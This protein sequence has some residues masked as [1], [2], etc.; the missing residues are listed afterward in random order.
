MSADRLKFFFETYRHIGHIVFGNN[1]YNSLKNKQLYIN[2][3]VLCAYVFKKKMTCLL[4]TRYCVMNKNKL[5]I[6]LFQVV[7]NLLQSIES[8]MFTIRQ[9]AI[10]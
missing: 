5:F 9:S 7:F 10:A 4:F 6:K 2:L 1:F 3:C 8:Q